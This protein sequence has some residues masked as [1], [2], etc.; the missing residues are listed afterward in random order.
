MQVIPFIGWLTSRPRTRRRLTDTGR[1]LTVIAGTVGY[2]GAMMVLFW[3]AMRGQS[4]LAPDGLTLAG[5]AGVALLT[6]AV[7]AAVR[8]VGTNNPRDRQALP[9][10]AQ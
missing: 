7:L 10:T 1:V 4:I 8:L 9:A 6:L 5:F 2:L 3:Q